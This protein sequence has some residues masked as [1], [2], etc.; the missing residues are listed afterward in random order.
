MFTK[1]LISQAIKF[2]KIR[3]QKV[4]KNTCNSELAVIMPIKEW[5]ILDWTVRP[6][7][8]TFLQCAKLT[9][10]RFNSP[11][12]SSEVSHTAQGTLQPLRG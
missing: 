8:T 2:V 9:E 6:G 12:M 4:L 7:P 3:G 1:M 10:L 5:V 11:V